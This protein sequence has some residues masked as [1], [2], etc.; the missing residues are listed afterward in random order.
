MALLKFKLKMCLNGLVLALLA[1]S[2]LLA[3]DNTQFSDEM[4]VRAQLR[5]SEQTTLSSEISSRLA[6]IK[7][8]AGD[9][10]KKGDIL[11]S[12][13]CANLYAEQK[14]AKAA[15]NV[16]MAKFSSLKRLNELSSASA[17][18]LQVAQSELEMAEADVSIVDKTVSHCN[19]IA[20]YDGRVMDRFVNSHQ[21]VKAGDPV[22]RI[23]ASGSIEVD[24]LIASDSLA[25]LS[26]GDLMSVTINETNKTIQAKV[27]GLGSF[28]D[29]VSQTIQVRAVI[30]DK[31]A[32]LLPGMS[33][34]VQFIR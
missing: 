12:F 8:D 4:I 30:L 23:Y 22:L 11:L 27:S 33:G 2:V 9:S 6:I 5:P 28:I 13:D 34:T 29:P 16:A 25:W 10:F 7:V 1:P 26:V 17:V 3:Q 21:F 31:N 15:H 18:E 19:I 24:F 32:T 20:P 14:K